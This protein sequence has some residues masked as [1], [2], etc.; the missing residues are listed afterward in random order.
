MELVEGTLKV[1]ASAASHLKNPRSDV[2]RAALLPGSLPHWLRLPE[3]VGLKTAAVNGSDVFY[4]LC[5]TCEKLVL[6]LKPKVPTEPCRAGAWQATRRRVRAWGWRCAFRCR[7]G[8]PQSAAVKRRVRECFRRYDY[9][10]SFLVLFS[11][12]RGGKGIHG[13]C[14]RV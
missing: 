4:E 13:G 5:E 3:G 1:L 14:L 10:G 6:G 12:E 9:E 8:K 2:I 11:L 7:N